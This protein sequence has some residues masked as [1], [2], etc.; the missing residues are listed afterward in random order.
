MLDTSQED[1]LWGGFFVFRCQTQ[2]CAT[3]AL[4]WKSTERGKLIR[5]HPGSTIHNIHNN[6]WRSPE[7]KQSATRWTNQSA[8]RRGGAWKVEATADA[9]MPRRRRRRRWHN[10]RQTTRSM[11][12]DSLADVVAQTLEIFERALELDGDVAE[13]L[14]TEHWSPATTSTTTTTKDN[15]LLSAVK[16]PSILINFD[17]I[18]PNFPLFRSNFP[19]FSYILF[20][21]MTILFNYNKEWMINSIIEINMIIRPINFD[22]MSPNFRYL[23]P[24]FPAFSS[25]YLN[26][27]LIFDFFVQQQRI[28][29]YFQLL[30]NHLY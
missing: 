16:Q 30:F 9:T 29:N 12:M 22:Q 26:F 14:C 5:A 18:S 4:E 20:Q 15:Q 17:Q 13:R 24:I 10:R 1:S 28:S 27:W 6:K 7:R 3:I 25:F 23:C 2:R 8:A 21:F 11:L 19:A